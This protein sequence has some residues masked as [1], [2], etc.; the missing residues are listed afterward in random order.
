M[1]VLLAREFEGSLTFVGVLEFQ[2][3]GNAHLHLLVGRY[4]AQ[5]WL[6]IACQS[7]GGG[8]PVDIPF[9]GEHRAA[10]HLSA[11]LTGDKVFRTLDSRSQRAR[12][13]TTSSSVSLLGQK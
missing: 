3:N 7:I 10:G 8:A 9:V 5:K 2:K 12:C 11:Y 6:S 13:I 4:I 1:R